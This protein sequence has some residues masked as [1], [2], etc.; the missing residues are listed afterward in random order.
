[1]ANACKPLSEG[2]MK[3]DYVRPSPKELMAY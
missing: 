1:M 3:L 2:R